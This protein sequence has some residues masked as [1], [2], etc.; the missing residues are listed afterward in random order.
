MAE[1][2]PVALEFA[3]QAIKAAS[4]TDLEQGID[5]EAE[6]FAQLFAHPDK[7]EGIDAFLEDRDPVWADR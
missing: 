2:S 6:L 4:R 7:D 1:K 5:Y 3:K